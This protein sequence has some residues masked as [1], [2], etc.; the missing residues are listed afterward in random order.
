MTKD[1]KWPDGKKAAFSII[2]DTDDAELPWIGEI[3]DVLRA[4]GLRTTKTVWVY[5]PRDP[6][7]VRGDS[8]G[9]NEEYVEF[10]RGL[11]ESGFEIGLHNVGSGGFTREETKE[12][13]EEFKNLLGFYPRIHINHSYNKEN[14]YSGDKRFGWPF[15]NLV[16][17][18]YSRYSGFEGDI[19]GSDYFWG[20]I[21][22][23][24]IKWSRSL[25]M[26]RL[27]VLDV[28]PVPYSEPRFDEY[29]NAFF[30]STFCP[31]QDLF[32]R[33]V[34]HK[35]VEKLIDDRG[36]SIVYTHFGY[37]HERGVIDAGFVEA[38]EILESYKQDIWFAPVGEILDYLQVQVGVQ[39][40]TEWQRMRLEFECLLTRVKYR[41]FVKLDDFHYKKSLGYRH[42]AD[43]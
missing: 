28:V 30:P 25:E 35:N 27:N 36:L 26:D 12:G 23:D 3:Y 31:N 10:I 29:A 4:S 37:Y 21:H 33:K 19:P 7:F 24:L 9:G 41:Y 22:K 20:D 5:P 2:D 32:K 43:G 1:L 13:I 42:R 16:R 14:I 11:I 39:P 15:R 6:E 17:L 8:L 18:M 40:I 34:T 38:C